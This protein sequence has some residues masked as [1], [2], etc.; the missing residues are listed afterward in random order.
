MESASL[1]HK[2]ASYFTSK[3]GVFGNGRGIAIWDMQAMAK[4]RVS[5]EN[6]GKEHYVRKRRDLRGT[7][8]SEILLEKSAS[9]GW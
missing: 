2:T 4:P 8:L 3:M 5:M 7:A 9:S 6:K 1:E